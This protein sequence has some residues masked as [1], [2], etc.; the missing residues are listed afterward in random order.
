VPARGGGDLDRRASRGLQSGGRPWLEAAGVAAQPP[1]A[2]GGGEDDTGRWEQGPA[3]GIQ[4]VAVVVVAEQDGVDR[5]QVGGRDRRA[6]QPV[7][8]KCFLGVMLHV[9]VGDALTDLATV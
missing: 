5:A 2:G 9:G 8:A 7:G 3:G 6:G 4:V 1:A